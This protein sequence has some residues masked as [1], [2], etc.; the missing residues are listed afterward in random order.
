MLR[1]KVPATL[2]KFF[3][4]KA[5]NPVPTRFRLRILAARFGKK[6]TGRK[7]SPIVSGPRADRQPGRAE[8]RRRLRQGRR[9]EPLRRGRRQRPAHRRH[10]GRHRH[11]AVQRRHR[12]RRRRGRLRV[13]V[14]QGPQRRRVPEPEPEP[15]LPRQAAVPEPALRRRRPRLRRRLADA[16]ERAGP[17]ALQL[18]REPHGDAHAD[19]AELLG[20]HAVLALHLRE[21]RPRPPAPGAAVQ[22]LPDA[23]ALPHLGVDA[24][25]R[26]GAALDQR[27]VRRPGR[28]RQRPL[29]HPRRRPRTAPSP[30]ARPT[31]PTTATAGSA[32]TSATRTPTGSPTTSSTAAR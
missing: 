29:R 31:R 7:L 30:R 14:G 26:P 22:H 12:R 9:Q 13:P 32:T 2:Q 25:L 8:P 3:A 5:G 17:V 1:V 20:R 24:R 10:R 21:R 6:F 19:A 27:H 16:R 28:R 11:G 4:V 18:L 23:G 15:A